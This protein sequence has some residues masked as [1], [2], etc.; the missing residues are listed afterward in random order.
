VSTLIY[1]ASP[2]SHHDAAVRQVRFESACRVTAELIRQGKAS[3]SPIAYSHPLC[4]YGLPLDWEF[5]QKHDLQ[6][7][8]MCSEVIVLKL[9]DWERS[10]GIQAEIAAARAMGK[11]VTFLEPTG[12][13]DVTEPGKK[14]N[15]PSE[16]A[17]NP[18]AR[19]TTVR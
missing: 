1:V 11:P 18:A 19:T 5:W 14:S 12:L 16:S 3:Y 7:L 6:F 4:R 13:C 17:D 10:V 2:Y 8:E 15:E 9:P